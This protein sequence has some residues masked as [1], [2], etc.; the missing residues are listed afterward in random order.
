MAVSPRHSRADSAAATLAG[1]SPTPAE[2]APIL[3]ER[4]AEEMIERWRQGERPLSEEFLNRHPE[5][6]QRP[7]EALELIYEEI[8]LRQEYGLPVTPEDF[9]RRFPQWREQLEVLLDCHRMLEGGQPSPRLPSVGDTVGEFQLLAEL[10]QG[11]NGRVFLATQP[12]LADRPIVLKLTPAAGREHLSLA[13]LQHTHIVPLY[14]VQNDASRNLRALCMPYFGGATLA[15]IELLLE[16]RPPALRLGEDFVRALD[17]AHKATAPIEISV[18]GPTC[19]FFSQTTYVRTICWIGACLADALDYARGRGLVHLDLKPSNVLI[20]AD[21]QPMLLDFHLARG[22]IQPQGPV[23]EWLGGTPAYMAPEQQVVL[24]AVRNGQKVPVAVDGRADIYSLGLLLYEAL[25]G[26]LPARPAPP[27]SRCCPLASVGLSD[28]IGKCLAPEPENRYPTATALAFDL[29]CHLADRPLRGV[30]N[31]SVTERWKKVQRRRPLA[32]VIAVLVIAVLA[33]G[34]IGVAHF[35]QQRAKAEAALTEGRNLWQRGHYDEAAVAL[36]HGLDLAEDI[37]FGRSQVQELTAQSGKVERARQAQLFHHLMDEVR[38]HYA[39]DTLSPRQRKSLE[40]HCGK[41][42][43]K[44]SSIQTVLEPGQDPQLQRQLQG[45]LLD[46]AVLWTDHRVRTAKSSEVQAVRQAGLKILDEVE[47]VFGPSR[48][49]WLERHTQA[50]ALG[51]KWEAQM[52]AR[53]QAE[54][55][56]RSAWEHYAWARFLLSKGESAHAAQELE[57]AIRSHPR[58]FWLNFYKGRSECRL[59]KFAEAVAA[60]TACIV[61]AEE[62]GWCYYNRAVAYTGLGEIQKALQDYDAALQRDP[63]LA[64]AWLNRGMLHHRQKRHER[65]RQDLQQALDRGVDSAVV[66]YNLALVY[67]AE[68]NLT[69]ALPRLRL[70]LVDDPEHEE[71]RWLFEKLEKR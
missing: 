35:R 46:L 22:P 56:S 16:P 41:L 15:Q 36:R 14:W 50:E 48:V 33:T 24:R 38:F 42:W 32:P 23:P 19:Q 2:P 12:S 11:A 9:I 21:G 67:L 54:L 68:G 4:Q 52:A 58:S 25:A 47:K 30:A 29:R 61:L 39:S 45:D 37:P 26:T 6:W 10:G 49:L 18:G 17:R 3:A 53:R 64:W 44:R 59:G 51:A 7:Q 62:P 65:A 63:K 31:R 13:R 8:C 69:A 27:L 34:T 60:F 1:D 43:H 40:A 70:T 66:H 20:T 5:L 57:E 71:A 28:I 55:P